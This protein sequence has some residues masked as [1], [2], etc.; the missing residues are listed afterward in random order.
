[1]LTTA[2]VTRSSIGASDGSGWPSSEA[3][4]AAPAGAIRWSESWRATGA[5]FS[6]S[7]LPATKPASAIAVATTARVSLLDCIG[8]PGASRT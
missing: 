5:A 8:P 7:A 3:G 4:S 2:G 1:M 6:C